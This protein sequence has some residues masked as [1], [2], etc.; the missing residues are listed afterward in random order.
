MKKEKPSKTVPQ[1]K[2]PQKS[3]S[4]FNENP[5]YSHRVNEKN[6]K[7]F[8]YFKPMTL[9]KVEPKVYFNARL[10]KA[11]L[12]SVLH[13]LSCKI[14]LDDDQKQLWNKAFDTLRDS[15]NNCFS[16]SLI[17]ADQSNHVPYDVNLNILKLLE[18]FQFPHE[19]YLKI[20]QH[21]D[22]SLFAFVKDYWCCC[23]E[24]IPVLKLPYSQYMKFYKFLW[25]PHVLSSE[26][27]TF[28]TDHQYQGMNYILVDHIFGSG[29]R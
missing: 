18:Q 3:V 2:Q 20:S 16:S 4:L 12:N 21:N 23:C 1:Q 28:T 13:K 7:G 14:E 22:N 15:L 11:Y 26:R 10:R 6:I 27:V 24:G 17:P 25:S 29:L 19:E 5:L 9:H 8:Y